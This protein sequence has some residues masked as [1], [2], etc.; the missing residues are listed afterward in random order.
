MVDL[1][2]GVTQEPELPRETPAA[3]LG[4]RGGLVGGK[5]RA[6]KM[7]AKERL[8]AARKAAKDA[9]LAASRIFCH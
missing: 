4:R 9:A 1:A 7:T 2:T 8:Q 3:E 6:A 5:A